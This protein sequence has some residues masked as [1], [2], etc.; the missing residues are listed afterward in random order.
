M[1]LTKAGNAHKF[2][3]AAI[4]LLNTSIYCNKINNRAGVSHVIPFMAQRSN[5]PQNVRNA[6]FGVCSSY[7][8]LMWHLVWSC[9][10]KRKE[11][12]P[13]YRMISLPRLMWRMC[14][15]LGADVLGIFPSHGRGWVSSS[16]SFAYQCLYM[17]MEAAFSLYSV[18]VTKI[19]DTLELNWL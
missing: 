14:L 12:F 13:A 2:Q 11:F 7:H 1:I 16:H 9:K 5:F 17:N 3:K 19:P 10:V 4:T 8:V 15:C 18:D 6:H